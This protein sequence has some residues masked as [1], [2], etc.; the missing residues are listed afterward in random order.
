MI[1][2]CY[3]GD[4]SKRSVTS[5]SRLDGM[6]E[7]STYWWLVKVWLQVFLLPIGREHRSILQHRLLAENIVLPCSLPVVEQWDRRRVYA[8]RVSLIMFFFR[9]LTLAETKTVVHRGASTK[10]TERTTNDDRPCACANG[11]RKIRYILSRPSHKPISRTSAKKNSWKYLST[12]KFVF[13]V[14]SKKYWPIGMTIT[15]TETSQMWR[16]HINVYIVENLKMI[17]WI[18]EIIRCL[19]LFYSA[20]ENVFL[21]TLLKKVF[22]NIENLDTF[23]FSLRNHLSFSLCFDSMI[24]VSLWFRIAVQS[25]NHVSLKL[26]KL[27]KQQDICLADHSKHLVD[28]QGRWS[29]KYLLKLVCIFLF[30]YVFI[31]L[32]R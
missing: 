24:W 4:Q 15:M 14:I 3:K 27:P 7:S 5:F 25:P 2:V 22:L 20:I 18:D 12:R 17:R 9:P 13:L 8:G 6:T 10:M 23:F 30:R 21:V 19:V 16:L 28:S 32:S 11:S 26:V 29:M 1:V 31:R